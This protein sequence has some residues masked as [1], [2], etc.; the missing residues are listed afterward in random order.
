MK[1]ITDR[2]LSEDEWEELE[3]ELRGIQGCDLG[4]W[5]QQ[6]IE[7]M[8]ERLERFGTNARVTARQWQQIERL[9]DEYQ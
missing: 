4:T 1:R 2:N 6:F 5:D 3:R 7:D 9:K 8:L